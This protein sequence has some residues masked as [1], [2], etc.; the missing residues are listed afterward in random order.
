[1]INTAMEMLKKKYYTFHGVFFFLFFKNTFLN[2]LMHKT[3]GRKKKRK[4]KTNHNT[5]DL[6]KAILYADENRSTTCATCSEQERKKKKRTYEMQ[7]D[8]SGVKNSPN[9]IIKPMA[10]LS[11]ALIHSACHMISRFLT[12]TKVKLQQIYL[13]N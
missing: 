2:K 4:P 10:K 6:F 1:M 5:T 3:D 13:P 11:A 7:T 8:A 9:Q 12:W